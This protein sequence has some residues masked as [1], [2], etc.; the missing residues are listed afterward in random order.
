MIS[1]IKNTLFAAIVVVLSW[2]LLSLVQD[3]D[4]QSIPNLHQVVSI[5]SW[6]KKKSKKEIYQLLAKDAK[7]AGIDLVKLRLLDQD[8]KNTKLVY[9]FNSSSKTQ[10]SWRKNSQVKRLS[11]SELMLEDVLGNYYTNATTAQFASLASDLSEAGLQVTVYKSSFKDELLNNTVYQDGLL[12]FSS[13]LGMLLII[14]I[15]DKSFRYKE[16][17]ILQVNGLSS[18]KIFR[19]DFAK[20]ILPFILTVLLPLIFFS[21]LAARSLNGQGSLF[22]I[23]A[24][25][26]LLL[27]LS[28]TY[29]IFDFISYVSLTLIKPYAAIKGQ[30]AGKGF[31]YL[32]Y[33]LKIA[34]VLLLGVNLASLGQKY[35]AYQQDKQIMQLWQKKPASYIAN[36]GQVDQG[37]DKRVKEIDRKVHRLVAS[38]KQAILAKNAQQFQPASSSTDIQN[39]NVLVV[40]PAFLKASSVK[41]K[42]GKQVTVND[43]KTVYILIPKD[44]AYQKAAFKKQAKSWIKFQQTLPNVY[45]K[46]K[47]IKYKLVYIQSQQV[48]NYTAGQDIAN[49][50][51]TDP[52]ILAIDAKLLSD[53]FFTA[54]LTQGQVVFPSLT[55]LQKGIKETGL[56]SFVNGITNV[57]STAAS[58]YAQ[59]LTELSII[60]VIAVLSLTQMFFMVSYVSA[61][62]FESKK[63]RLTV[64][65]VFGLSNRKLVSQFA[66]ANALTDLALL[67]I[68][69]VRQGQAG[70]FWLGLLLAALEVAA[71]ALS[72]KQAESNMLRGLNR[73]NWGWIMIKAEK[74][75][76]S[77][78]EKVIL[79]E[80][81]FQLESGKSYAIVGRSGAGKSTLLNMLSGLEKA[82]SGRVLI[83]DLEVNKQN[84]KRLR[85]EKFGYVF[86]NF[87]LIDN[88]SIESNLAIGLADAKGSRKEKQKLMRQ[89]LDHLDVKA[90]LAQTAY[91]LSGGEQQRV[92][93]AR[94]LLKKPQ[95]IFA[96]EPTGSLDVGNGQLVLYSLLSDFGSDATLLIATHSPAVWQQCDYI[97]ELAKQEIQIYKN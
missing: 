1:K 8:G 84:I 45:G 36:L 90:D 37:N 48:F 28:V 96:D 17:A 58:L 81:S 76:K 30:F 66:L 18:G 83:D 35:S 11:K 29:W 89:V 23:K 52:I 14:M 47:Q 80:S 4:L 19:R 13:L 67:T 51:S 12:V 27:A 56:T 50:V 7:S 3:Y 16:Y 86:Q 53:D 41:D 5:T 59:L 74:L 32:G 71:I 63:R 38:D 85:R 25:F 40:N 68:M 82:T 57:K 65:Q 64:Y 91:S 72:A 70:I 6:D 94:I 44:R 55:K 60:G 31:L 61:S 34:I 2:L 77:F 33:G 62:F 10:Y 9:N 97:I 24:I 88:E 21:L 26:L 78:G 42:Q 39:G 43:A 73:G 95:I 69:L 92:A 93:L 49:S 20:E 54:S 75:S 87:A 15:L 46:T 79:K 22:Y